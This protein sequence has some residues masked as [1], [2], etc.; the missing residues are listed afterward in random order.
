A[1][2][3]RASGPVCEIGCGPGQ[4]ARYLQDRGVNMRGLDLSQEM[5]KFASQLNPDISFARGDMLALELPRASL[6]GI[7]CFYAIIHLKRADAPRALAEMH[8]VL[9][10]GGKLLLS[11]HRGVGE[12]HREE[13]YDMPVSIDVALFEPEE[14]A[15]YLETAG[16]EVERMV[17]R[18]PYEFEYPTGRVY[19]CARKPAQ[20]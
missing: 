8:R 14:M 11:F 1:A 15:G 3:V 2:S 17:E 4:I 9:K 12:L 16:F 19:A 20:S 6:A 18:A 7:V 5:I 13:W 10:P